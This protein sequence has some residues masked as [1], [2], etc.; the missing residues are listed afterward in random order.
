MSKKCSQI[1]HIHSTYH[2]QIH[3]I[4]ENHSGWIL[5]TTSGI[6]KLFP[7]LFPSNSWNFSQSGVVKFWIKHGSVVWQ[8]FK[9]DPI[10]GVSILMLCVCSS[11][12]LVEVSLHWK[13]PSNFG[14]WRKR[15]NCRQCRFLWFLFYETIICIGIDIAS[16]CHTKMGKDNVAYTSP[17]LQN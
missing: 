9:R 11:L 6:I 7:H 16:P 2:L 12:R 10:K 17:I 5:L 3:K 8:V 15:G 14:S 13:L 4:L 1:F